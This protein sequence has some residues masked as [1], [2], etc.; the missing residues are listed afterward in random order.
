MKKKFFDGVSPFF[1]TD[2]TL[3]WKTVKPFFSNQENNEVSFYETSLTSIKL[4][5]VFRTWG[6][7]RQIKKT[8]SN[9]FFCSKKSQNFFVL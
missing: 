8:N 2:N 3:F 7:L 9:S 4:L 5:L 6:Y 1:V